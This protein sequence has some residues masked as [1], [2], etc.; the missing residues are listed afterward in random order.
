MNEFLLILLD[1]ILDQIL[2]FF[3]NVQ[4]IM[5]MNSFKIII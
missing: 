1:N 3:N 4:V 5:N 2:I